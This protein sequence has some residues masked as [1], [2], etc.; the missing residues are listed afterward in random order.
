MTHPNIASQ[1]PGVPSDDFLRVNGLLDDKVRILMQDGKSIYNEVLPAQKGARTSSNGL[2]SKYHAVRTN[3]YASKKE[4]KFAATL[5]MR[6]NV[7]EIDFWLEQVRLPLD[8][9][10]DKGKPYEYRV[11]FVLFKR[12]EQTHLPLNWLDWPWHITWVEVK[13]YDN[14][15][16]KMKR[17]M[18]E[19]KYHIKI[20]IV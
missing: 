18:A 5:P 11:D 20:Q 19:Q 12:C 14:K 1:L 6:E 17:K 3:G 15:L 9:M 16:G 13:G 2:S 10:T 7:G 8:G 4:A